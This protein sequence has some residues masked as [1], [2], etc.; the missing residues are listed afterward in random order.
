MPNAIKILNGYKKADLRQ[1][2]SEEQFNQYIDQTLQAVN[3][4]YLRST[5]HD[6]GLSDNTSALQSKYRAGRE[7]ANMLAH[8]RIYTSEQIRKLCVNYGL[9]FLSTS[10]YI[11]MLDPQGIAKG[12]VA[13]E[14]WQKSIGMTGSVAG[15]R[16]R[17]AAPPESFKLEERPIPIVNRDPLLFCQIGSSA[18]WFL[19]HKWGNDLSPVR[20]VTQWFT[21]TRAH[22]WFTIQCV[23][24]LA[25]AIAIRGFHC[26]GHAQSEGASVLFGVASAVLLICAIIATVVHAM[27]W[28][29][30]SSDSYIK[31]N[32]TDLWQSRHA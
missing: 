27:N 32:N 13:Y 17:I 25:A 14:E 28:N 7:N 11:G 26:A 19:I 9:R 4:E 8:D 30:T 5:L 12:C 1:S 15:G 16:C 22:L 23:I 10:M 18:H 24:L 31:R 29:D 20:R 6:V 2:R 3:D 21:K